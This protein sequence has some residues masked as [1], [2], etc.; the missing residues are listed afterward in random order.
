MRPLSAGL[1]AVLLATAPLAAHADQQV[2]ID[3]HMFMPATVTIHP[4]E[5]VT[6]VNKD[7]DVH[8]VTSDDQGKSFHTP[9][10]DTGESATVT[11][12][13]PGTFGYHC[14]VHPDMTGTV[15]VK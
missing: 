13:T 1:L 5:K 15:I 3:Q 10:L 2:A 14:S 12:A 9:L 8:N 6:W 11:F 7:Q 4:G